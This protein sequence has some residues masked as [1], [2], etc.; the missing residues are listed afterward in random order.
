MYNI[1]C[2]VVDGDVI[3]GVEVVGEGG[4]DCQVGHRQN[5]QVSHSKYLDL[6]REGRCRSAR[7]PDLVVFLGQVVV[8]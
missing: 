3:E 1:A 7:L 6:D 8:A 2:G 4:V 5:P